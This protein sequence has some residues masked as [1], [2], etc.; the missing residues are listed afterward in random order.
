MQTT[1]DNS[2]DPLKVG[3]QILKSAFFITLVTLFMIATCW[4]QEGTPV[5]NSQPEARD[6]ASTSTEDG[7][8]DL[9]NGRDLTGWTTQGNWLPQDD[10]S[11]LI[12][13]RE[14]EQGWGRF[15]SYLWT[16]RKYK[17]FELRVECA[18]PEH[19]N[20]GIY[21]RVDDRNNPVNT[22]IEAQ[23][24][25]SSTQKGALNG[26]TLGGVIPA[27]IPPSKN[28]AKPPGEW[29]QMVIR[30]V[31]ERIQIKVNGTQVI[32]INLPETSIRD[33]N[34][35]GYIGLQDHGVPHAIRFR[36]IRIK[37]IKSASEGEDAKVLFDNEVLPIFEN[38]CIYCHGED[39]Q[40]GDLRL[41]TLANVMRGGNSGEPTV[42]VGDDTTKSHLVQLLLSEDEDHRMPLENDPLSDADIELIRKWI[43]VTVGWDEAIKEARVKKSNHWSFQPIQKPVPPQ[44]LHPN[45]I[46][47]LIESRLK[48]SQ[49]R[50]S[51]EASQRRLIRRLYLVL[52]GFPPTPKQISD[53]LA[54]ERSNKWELLVEQVLASPHY[55]ERIAV[56][57]LDLIRF[58][59]TD[60]FEVNAERPGAWRYRDW[61]IKAFNDDMPYDQFINKQLAGDDQMD[62][63]GS[64]YLVAGAHNVVV[65]QN[66]KGQAD[67]VQ[68]EVSDFLNTTGTTFLG[69]T[70][71][72]ARC[73]NHKFDPVSQKDFYSV[74]AVFSGVNHGLGSIAATPEWITEQTKTKAEIA[75]AEKRLE[76][77]A[78]K[79][80]KQAP[81]NAV[82]NIESFTPI[83]ARFVRLTINGTRGGRGCIDE[84]EIF[85]GDENLALTSKGATTTSGGDFVH[86]RHRLSQINDGKYGNSFSWISKEIKG[87]VQIKLA[88]DSKIDRIIWGRDRTGTIADRLVNDYRIEVSIDQQTWVTVGDSRQRRT[89]SEPIVT[90]A[91]DNLP[92]AESKAANATYQSLLSMEKKLARPS[93]AYVGTFSPPQPTYRLSRGDAMSPQERVDPNTISLL[94]DLLLPASPTGPQRRT[95]FA[96]WISSPKNPLTARVMVNRIWQFHFGQGLVSTPNDFGINGSPP[97]HPELLDYLAAEFIDSDWSVKHIHR[98]ILTSKTW[99][100]DSRP[101]A[102]A[103]KQDSS[104]Q[105]LWRFPPHRLEAEAIRDS[106]LATTNKLDLSIG[107]PGFS[108][109]EVGDEFVRHYFPKKSFG[110]ADWRRMVYMTRVRKEVESVFGVFDCPEGNQGTPVRTRSTTPLQALNLFNSEFVVQQAEFFA[111]RLESG[112][113]NQTAIV[114][115]SYQ[116]CFGRE[117]SLTEAELAIEMIEQI[118][119]IQYCRI[120]LNSNEF[121]FIL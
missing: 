85:S 112:G 72:C 5:S 121:V 77:Y 2:P 103:L 34:R 68:N 56:N 17:D 67:N 118:G 55:G 39:E 65:E 97:S 93:T 66:K 71:G 92:E 111:K 37:E 42:V 90:Y 31:G 48:D 108:G 63:I 22:G 61:V 102:A 89:D 19:G 11:L 16:E 94:G 52:H 9:Y 23:V 95:A 107:G 7:F 113:K 3:R 99:R 106:I 115:E 110:P 91:F 82:K 30:C 76:P 73:H 6:E 15:G 70:L 78:S 119:L 81:V 64:A 60:G 36:N 27:D 114:T 24:F 29:N 14:H 57:W 53:Y 84:L 83:N 86:V 49:L 101:N 51:D 47:S 43:R 59:E 120:L 33:R 46:D 96:K 109:F 117:P 8:V 32:N 21:F 69:I 26:H 105:L 50:F 104:T 1:D 79:S 10:G 88:E 20:S 54:D 28:M 25:D 35:Q 98:L 100:Q 45:P 12:Q 41:D 116:L 44:T 38:S 75:Q 80:T 58:S 87:W 74:Q 62:P 40:K 4:S 13:P 18:Y